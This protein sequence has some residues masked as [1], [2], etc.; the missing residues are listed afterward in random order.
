MN[1]RKIQSHPSEN[2]IWERLEKDFFMLAKPLSDKDSILAE[3]EKL[4]QVFTQLF[5]E[6]QQEGWLGKD[7][8]EDLR[9]IIDDFIDNCAFDRYVC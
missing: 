1:L 4:K 8:A 6:I 2:E 9:F 7:H 3:R 5:D